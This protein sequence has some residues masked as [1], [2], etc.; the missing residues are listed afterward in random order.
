MARNVLFQLHWFLGITAGLVLAVMGVTGAIIAFEPELLAATN[1]GIVTVAPATARLLSGPELVAHVEARHPGARIT[2]LVTQRDPARAAIVTYTLGAS[3][4]RLRSYLDPATGAMLG[5]AGGARFFETVEKLHRWMALP[6]DGNGWGRQ[7][8]GF[9]ALSLIYFALSGL[10]LR[11]PRRPL[12][13]RNWFVLDLRKTG[14]NLHRALHAVVGGWVLVFY[15]ISGSTGLWWSYGWYRDGVQHLL[16][17]PPAATKGHAAKDAR[18][19][20]SLAWAGFVRASG[21]RAYEQ[22][23][24]TV[25]DGATVQFRGK[26]PGGR[27]DRVSDEITIDGT[28]GAM[29]SSTPYAQRRWGE[30][31]V[32]SVYELHRGAYFGLPG[33]IVMLL[34]SMTMPLFT[35]TGLLLYLARRRRKAALA[36]VVRDAP[37]TPGG[38]APTI[39][40]FAS[41]TGSAERI[42]QLTA[43]A[44][45]G[46]AA[47]PVAALTPETLAQAT[48][49]FVVAS[50]Y[51]EGEPP[52]AARGFARTMSRGVADLPH[53]RYAVLA[54]GDREYADFCAFGHRI[55]GWL[56]A[57]GATRLF[58]LIEMHGDDPD[59]QRQWQQQLVGVGARTDQPDWAPAPMD[60]WR[61]VERRLLNPGSSGGEAWHIA[62]EPVDGRADWQAG[63]IIEILPE[64][65]PRRVE[66][67]LRA[68]RMADTPEL[69][70]LLATHILPDDPTAGIDPAALK[71]LAHRDYSIASIPASGRVELI[72]RRCDAADGFPGL[73]SGW[74][75]GGAPM[76][77]IVRARTRR[78]PSFHAPADPATPLILIGNGTGLAGLLAHLRHRAAQGG[79]PAWLFWGE[80][81]PDHDDYH[82]AERHAHAARGT[83]VRSMTAWSR[84]GCGPRYV[85]DALAASADAVAGAVALGAAIYVCGSM[86]GM[87]VGVQQVLTAAL[88]DDTLEAMLGDGRYRRDIY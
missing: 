44:L 15:L 11:W 60:D 31:I 24:A 13:W 45:P 79:G 87:A 3:K 58:D 71:P 75:T 57:S 66:A 28:S 47:V 46:A 69:R 63:D 52:D 80:R 64:H 43:Q 86:D 5:D 4:E 88:G 84:L 29:L 9:A 36:A 21:G 54:L 34:T 72:V 41:Q 7:I 67:F 32:T 33:R 20:L 68:S 37:D 22:V 42:A 70:A 65:D 27:H 30:D 12:D 53:L 10:Y 61:L 39:V 81:H 74:L 8:T 17:S 23:T 76:G 62:L 55:D 73:G 77:G 35:I 2:R 19:D 6:G 18:A 83:L 1:P 49:L 14:R 38:A 16:T 85:Q 59:V 26:L 50:T 25:R 51:G 78:N 82:A 48:R 56:H 40:A